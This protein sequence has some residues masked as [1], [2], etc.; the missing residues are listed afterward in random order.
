MT[1]ADRSGHTTAAETGDSTGPGSLVVV[2]GL[3]GVG[4][5]TVAMRIADH[6]DSEILRTDVIRK[7]L[8]DDPSY[9]AD[10][11]AAVYD[12][13]IRRARERLV[14]GVSVVL[15]A[16]FAD[17]TFRRNA[18]AMGEQV[19]ESFDLVEVACDESVVKR[20]IE[21]RD[22]ISDADFQV[23]LH[24]RE[25]FDRIEPDHLVIDNSR[26]EAATFAQVDAA[27]GCER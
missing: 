23:H 12:A 24:F 25:E 5:T 3:P 26:N 2:C 13:L 11:T 8:F 14:T 15:D 19:A 18:R 21:Q 7:S 4:K 16:T 9:T 27:F 20:R 17:A 6:L 1:E 10:E 22:G